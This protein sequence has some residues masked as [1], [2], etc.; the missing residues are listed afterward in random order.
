MYIILLF[1]WQ[2]IEPDKKIKIVQQEYQAT[3][4]YKEATRKD[5]DLYCITVSNRYGEDSADIEVVVLGKPQ[6][7]VG[8]CE[9]LGPSYILQ[10]KI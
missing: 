10:T 9:L 2:P 4:T 6:S 1:Y 8:I 7:S 5:T 3:L